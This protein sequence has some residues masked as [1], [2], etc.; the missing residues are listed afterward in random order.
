MDERNKLKELTVAENRT[1][2]GREVEPE[3]GYVYFWHSFTAGCFA[4]L[5]K[6]AGF[7]VDIGRALWNILKTIGLFFGKAYLRIKAFF[8]DI[9]HKWK[10]NDKAGRASFFLFGTSSLTHKQYFNAVCY[11]VFE[12]GYIVF[13]ALSG[14]KAIAL[15]TTLGTKK[16]EQVCVYDPFLDSEIC[17][18]VSGDNSLLALINGI[19]VVFSVVFFFYIWKRS[20]N[21]GY[22]N[23]RIAHFTEFDRRNKVATPYSEQIYE[24]MEKNRLYEKSVPLDSLYSRYSD[25]FAKVDSLEESK[26][27]K[28]YGRYLLKQTI[29]SDK[30]YHANLNSLEKK[31]AK[32]VAKAEALESKASYL[33]KIESMD[34]EVASLSAQ[35]QAMMATANDLT[36]KNDL[37]AASAKKKE[38][39]KVRVKMLNLSN[40][41]V[42]LKTAHMNKVGAISE[43]IRAYSSRIVEAEKTASCFAHADSVLNHSKYGKFNVYY[44]NAA[45]FEQKKTFYE[46][47]SKLVEVYE[48]GKANFEKA[49]EE[50]KAEQARIVKKHESDL[51][52]IEKKYEGIAARRAEVL[53]RFNA[54]KAAYKEGKITKE[55]Y[56][57]HCKTI[58]GV[59]LSL[60]TVKEVNASHK[61]DINN[62]DHAYKRDY[63]ALKTNYTAIEYA[64]FSAENYMLINFKFTYNLAQELIKEVEA[65]MDAST[66]DAKKAEVV[67]ASSEYASSHPERFEG[68]PSGFKKTG[69]SLLDENF[70]VTLLALPVLGVVVFV[71]MPL[72]L[73]ILVGFTNYDNQHTPPGALFTWVGFENFSKL[74]DFGGGASS[75]L[76]KGLVLTFV[77]TIVWA[78]LA[79]FTNYFLGIIYALMINKDGIKFKSFW[80]FVFVLSI[81]VPQ[82]I[83]LIGLSL[84][85]KDGGALGK[86]WYNTFGTDLGFGKDTTNNAL[87]TKAIIILV[88]IWI[89]IPYTILQTTGILL[90]IPNDLYESSR[91]DG[92]GAA[93]QFFKITMPYIFFVTGPSLIQTFIGNINNFGVIYFLTGGGPNN[94]NVIANVR[95]GETDLFITY[96]YKLVTAKNNEQYGLAS[97][98]GIFVFIIC[99]II[100]MI[101]YNKSSSVAKED[102]FQ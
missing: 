99:A 49:N 85:L 39:R 48:E 74:L 29:L 65:H 97:A 63:K 23:Y 35:Y 66:I 25:I 18:A 27:D 13:M 76:G 6:I 56:V 15:L 45:S 5:M 92:A 22:D 100:S 43:S 55:E 12:I 1:C 30:E 62:A 51:A 32:L 44:L 83:S 69:K 26:M 88:N 57:D 40:K 68:R 59:L 50:N 2:L 79:T 36:L 33:E 9:G 61:E 72:L 24:D 94:P 3:P 17:S 21:A 95:L 90:N 96:I 64:R 78:I 91:I 87:S 77:W 58:K 80:R 46:N 8:K 10:F 81:A 7:F 54:E 93:T 37:K 41:E 38:A 19:L 20:I 53:S 86:W 101:I 16:T 67:K 71:L 47:Y 60:P 14:F 89:G 34:K 75:G 70:H 102:Q 98:I 73:S 31:K 82:F 52:E 28:A 84:I 4:L 42:N 11:M